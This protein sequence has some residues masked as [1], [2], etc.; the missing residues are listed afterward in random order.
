MSGPAWNRGKHQ[1]RCKRDHDNWFV[2]GSG[3]RRCRTCATDRQRARRGAAPKVM[4]GTWAD[5]SRPG[6][7]GARLDAFTYTDIMKARGYV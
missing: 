3:E 1:D 7:K 6:D 4:Q 2:D 5:Y